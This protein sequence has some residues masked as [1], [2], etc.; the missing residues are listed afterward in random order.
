[1]RRA[2]LLLGVG[3]Q[4]LL[5]PDVAV[6]LRR[7]RVD[8]LEERLLE[9]AHLVHG[10]RVEVAVGAGEDRD[11]LAL[12]RQRLVLVLLE[13]LD[14][15]HA[16]VELALGR[17]VELGAELREGRHLAVLGQVEAQAPGDLLHALDL[18]A[19]ADAGDRDA[20]VDRRLDAGVEEVGLE[21]DLPVGDRDD[22]RR[23]VGRDVAGLRL[24]DRQRGERA[25]AELLV[26]LRG[27]LEQARVQVEDVAGERLAAGGAAQQQRE[28]AVGGGL[29][30]EVVVDDQR[31][32]LGVAE[33]LAHRAAGVGRD[34]LQRRR[35]GGVGGDDD[36]VVHRAVVLEG[37][38]D[39]GDRG[40][41]LADRDVDADH[42]AALLVDDRVDA[43]SRS[44][45]S[46]GRR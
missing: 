44:C 13:G 40:G 42:V 32:A 28:L 1:M 20:D 30:G 19:A 22:V 4:F 26:D 35:V 23:D 3:E 14:H 31:V 41:L 17:G 36:R 25:A 8:V 5:L 15:A 7:G 11:D 34:V 21:E 12:D 16:A 9:L 38:D 27:A 46:G 39:A 6:D 43:R 33:V 37:L 10:E 2:Q 45:R 24:D 18:G 29:L